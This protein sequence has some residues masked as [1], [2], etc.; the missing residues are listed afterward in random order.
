[1]TNFFSKDPKSATVQKNNLAIFFFGII[2][3]FFAT[4]LYDF[5]KEVFFEFIGFTDDNIRDHVCLFGIVI[6]IIIV[7]LLEIKI[8]GT[9]F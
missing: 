1:M 3:L 4:I 8:E 7:I 6:I 5:Y 2:G 9:K